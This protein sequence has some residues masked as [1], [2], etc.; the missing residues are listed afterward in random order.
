ME[1]RITGKKGSFEEKNF[2]ESGLIN[3]QSV[4]AFL[5]GSNTRKYVANK[6]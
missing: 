3:S 4:T 6:R 1:L 5:E 2:L